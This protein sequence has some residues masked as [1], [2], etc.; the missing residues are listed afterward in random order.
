M[1]NEKKLDNK[2]N[3]KTVKE[4][5]QEQI[6]TDEKVQQEIYSYVDKKMDSKINEIISNTVQEK[7]KEYMEKMIDSDSI[8]LNYMEML[9]SKSKMITDHIKPSTLLDSVTYNHINFDRY[10]M[11]TSLEDIFTKYNIN[12]SQIAGMIGI[13]RAT[14]NNI[15]KDP[16]SCSLLNAYKLSMI[17]GVSLEDLFKY[18]LI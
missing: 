9:Y 1:D 5:V 8:S 11:K 7:T 14:L 6:F 4:I 17:F 2:K 13:N 16:N 18:V 12:K 15:I 10:E 3:N